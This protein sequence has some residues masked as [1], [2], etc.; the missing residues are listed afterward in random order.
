MSQSGS[1][2]Q[3][4]VRLDNALVDR[5]LAPSR[6]RARDAILRGH[7]KV[8]GTPAEK[9]SMAVAADA[10]L[11]MDDPVATYVSRAALKLVAALDHFGYSPAGMA[12]LDIGASTGGFTEVLLRRGARR[13]FGVDVGHGQLHRRIAEDPRVVNLEGVNARDLKPARI[14]EPV[15]AITADVSFISLKLALPPALALATDKAW[16]VFLVKPQFEVGRDRVGKG[17]IVRD[18]A[19]RQASA[20]EIARWLEADMRWRADGII[21]SPIEGGDGNHE[22]LL[23]AQRV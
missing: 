1:D 13:V 19:V 15:G 8:D 16:G 6:A 11:E 23:G 20:A 21:D 22:Y 2:D 4:A 3:R 5:G 7:V 12:A 10:R 18:P 14:T 9:P 17:G